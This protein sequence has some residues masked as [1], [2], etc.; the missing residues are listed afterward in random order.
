[1]HETYRN[2]IRVWVEAAVGAGRAATGVSH[3][4]LR[5]EVREILVRDLFRPLLP[6][7]VGVGTG[8]IISYTNQT[9]SQTDI[10]LFDR[11]IL[12]P[13]LFEDRLGL[14]PIESVL[15]A[16]EV[17]SKL[18]ATSC[19]MLTEQQPV[20]QNSRTQPGTTNHREFRSINP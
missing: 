13:V 18:T 11:R 15:Y 6:A 3:L 14:F 2:F 9:S 1:M 7:D 8:E 16:I 10:I 12:P 17:K 5:G 20:S 19:G 4:G